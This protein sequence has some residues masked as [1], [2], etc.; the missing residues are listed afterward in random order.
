MHATW[1]VKDLQFNI[2]LVIYLLI[3]LFIQSQ[4]WFFYLENFILL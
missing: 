3:Y 2:Y 1:H 4:D